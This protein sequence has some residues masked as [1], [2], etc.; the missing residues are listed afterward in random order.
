VDRRTFLVLLAAGTVGALELRAWR[1]ESTSAKSAPTPSR[2]TGSVASLRPARVPALTETAKVVPGPVIDRI[3]GPGDRLALTIDDGVSSEVVAGYLQFARDTGAR[4]TFFVNGIR[5]S[6]TENASQLRPLIET[7]QVQVA[8]HSW[9][10]PSLVTLSDSDVALQID[11]NE[12]FLRQTY[13]VSGRPFLRPPYGDYN[14]HTR[15]IAADHGYWVTTM[16]YGSLGDSESTVTEAEVL[17]NA[18]QWLNAQ[19]IVIGHAN[20]PTI[21]KVYGQL[22]DIIRERRLQMVTLNE[23]FNTS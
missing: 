19:S 11:K 4:L 8:N 18:R 22:A 21:T 17:S 20:L 5:P 12:Q 10:H 14:D 9:S 2:P 16:W 1:G 13:G 7:G 23:A 3:P 15:Q 6:W